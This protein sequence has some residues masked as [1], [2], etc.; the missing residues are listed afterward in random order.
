MAFGENLV[1]KRN[2]I[3]IDMSE[4]KEA[5][6]I[7][8]I[9]G[10]PPGYIGYDDNNSILEI[11]RNKPNSVLILDEIEKAHSNIIN[12]FF[13]VLDEG[14]IKTSKGNLVRFDN[15]VIIMTSNVGFL[16][17][18]VGFNVSSSEVTKLNDSFSIPF[19]N[20]VDNI[21]EFNNLNENNI[22]KIIELKLQELKNKYNNRINIK[23]ENSIL[24]DILNLTNYKIYGARKIDKIIKDKVEVQIIDSIIDD[25]SEIYIKGLMQ[26]V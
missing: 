8:K 7:S 15:V 13:Q 18:S 26:E 10:S 14:K 5:H 6:S 4:Y 1:G 20:R 16:E 12:L 19:M 3:K 22:R 11:I 17:S 24:D 9:I 25:K 23:I 2:V 21:V